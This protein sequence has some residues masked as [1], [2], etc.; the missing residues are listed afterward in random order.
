MYNKLNKFFIVAFSL[1][2]LC[3]CSTELYYG[4]FNTYYFNIYGDTLT[5]NISSSTP[6]TSSNFVMLCEFMNPSREEFDFIK[7]HTKFYFQWGRFYNIESQ[8][9]PSMQDDAPFLAN[10][11]YILDSINNVSYAFKTAT[12]TDKQG[13]IGDE[14]AAFVNE[15]IASIENYE[16]VKQD[17]S[18][19]KLLG[20]HSFYYLNEP[21]FTLKNKSFLWKYR[22][23]EEASFYIL[24]NETDFV[25]GITAFKDNENIHSNW[26]NYNNEIKITPEKVRN[27]DIPLNEDYQESELD[28]YFGK[29]GQIL[30][31]ESFPN[32]EGEYKRIASKYV[33]FLTIGHSF[34][35][36]FDVSF[37]AD[38]SNYDSGKDVKFPY[39]KIYDKQDPIL[40][41]NH[42][43]KAQSSA[44]RYSFRL[45]TISKNSAKTYYLFEMNNQS[46]FSESEMMLHF[47]YQFE[48]S[49][50]FVNKNFSFDNYAYFNDRFEIDENPWLGGLYST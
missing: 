34:I 37:D 38:Q 47:E 15:T 13:K 19:F 20:V 6:H 5:F 35:N 18:I 11:A 26:R 49:N 36:G 32:S 2:S 28:E 43:G 30:F 33:K 40:K 25:P 24:E 14:I 41:Y 46:D 10:T 44:W 23:S 12:D 1:F 21:Y 45:P 8:N 4:P 42:G 39:S 7:R 29:S 22:Y 17:E 3:S 50:G 16:E 31:K 27:G 9:D 48:V